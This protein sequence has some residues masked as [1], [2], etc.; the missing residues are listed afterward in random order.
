MASG[1]ENLKRR[2]ERVEGKPVVKAEKPGRV[3]YVGDGDTHERKE[4]D[5][6]VHVRDS[7]FARQLNEFG[8][9][10]K[11]IHDVGIGGV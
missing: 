9:C 8:V 1:I 5:F 7:E 3:V 2:I 11:V 6:V 10:G 4:G